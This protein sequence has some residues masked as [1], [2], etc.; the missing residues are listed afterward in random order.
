M[1]PTLKKFRRILAILLAPLGLAAPLAAAN[2]GNFGEGLDQAKQT[3]FFQWFNLEQTDLTRT[4]GNAVVSFKPSGKK[5]HYL[6]TVKVTTEAGGRI[7]SVEMALARSF[8]D[9]PQ[10][11]I[12]ARDIAKS[13][14]QT[15]LPA[16]RDREMSDLINE[17]EHQ[18]ASTMTIIKRGGHEPK[19]PE[20]PTPGYLTY[21]GNQPSYEHRLPGLLLRLEN[22]KD[23]LAFSLRGQ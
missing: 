8:I 10:D 19:L 16:P 11:G 18:G 9:D 5:F 23:A 14:L 6:V 4:G 3:E 15:A 12:F 20:K 1:N 22:R 21:L 13:F 17:I 7:L 2:F